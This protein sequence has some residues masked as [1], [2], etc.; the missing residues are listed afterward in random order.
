MSKKVVLAM[1]LVLC[2]GALF[3]YKSKSREE[4][5]TD[6]V[7]MKPS[8]L[9]FRS[10]NVLGQAPIEVKAEKTTELPKLEDPSLPPELQKKL[11]LFRSLLLAKNDNDPRWDTELKNNPESFHR[12][13]RDF[14]KNL[15][16]EMLN[17]RGSVSF[18]IARDLNSDEDAKFLVQVFEESPCL[19]LAN[20]QHVTE[21]NPHDTSVVQTTLIYP[22]LSI[23][24]QLE[25]RLLRQPELLQDPKWLERFRDILRSAS[26]FPVE[27]VQQRAEKLKQKFGL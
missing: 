4:T 24:Y 6:T 14:Y 11:E 25:S 23:L 3:F 5:R 13:L 21:D 26:Q 22:Q 10:S 12:A 17:E 15:A 8:Q 19:S 20:C 7:P 1:S 18:L 9:D 2:V 27:V 16:P